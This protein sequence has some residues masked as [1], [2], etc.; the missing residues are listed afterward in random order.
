VFIAY[1][2]P[3]TFHSFFDGIVII[4]GFKEGF[5]LTPLAKPA[6]RRRA[7]ACIFD[8]LNELRPDLVHLEL[9][10]E[11]PNHVTQMRVVVAIQVVV[12]PI[13]RPGFVSH[14]LVVERLPAINC[15]VD[16][17]LLGCGWQ[18]PPASELDFVVFQLLGPDHSCQVGMGMRI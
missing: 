13:M 15:P 6:F 3:A 2:D 17:S 16:H 7:P 10:P 18:H 8:L 14:L 9:G 4:V 1:A 12:E 5:V 11:W